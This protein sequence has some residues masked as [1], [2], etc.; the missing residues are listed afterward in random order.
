MIERGKQKSA[1]SSAPTPDGAEGTCCQEPCEELL[2]QILGVVRTVPFAPDKCVERMPI[3]PAEVLQCGRGLSR[4][5][6]ARR[7]HHAPMSGV[8]RPGSE[9]VL[10]RFIYG[11][12]VIMSDQSVCASPK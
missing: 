7:Q 4:F 8:E 12:S 5:G 1:E 10:F 9:R 2:C 3:D 6:L 11:H